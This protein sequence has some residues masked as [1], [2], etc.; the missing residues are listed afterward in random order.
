MFL[1]ITKTKQLIREPPE[2]K[3]LVYTGF[4]YESLASPCSARP[5]KILKFNPILVQL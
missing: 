4:Y 3:K 2:P 1:V 5:L